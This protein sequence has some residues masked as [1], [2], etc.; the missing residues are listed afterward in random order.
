MP[1]AFPIIIEGV[2]GIVSDKNSRNL[3][4][5]GKTEILETIAGYIPSASGT[6]G[7]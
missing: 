2:T 4:V 5:K 1:S 6:M 3:T 7:L